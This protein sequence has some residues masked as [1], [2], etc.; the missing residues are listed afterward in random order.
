MHLAAAA[1]YAHTSQIKS[2]MA[3]K[4]AKANLGCFVHACVGQVVRVN[5]VCAWVELGIAECLSYADLDTYSVQASYI[6]VDT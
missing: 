4:R 5:C 3:A 6:A 1:E 2:H